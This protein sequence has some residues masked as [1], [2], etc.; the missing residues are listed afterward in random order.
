ML[1]IDTA[2]RYNTISVTV[3]NFLVISIAIGKKQPIW[4]LV[5]LKT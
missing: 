3:I 4:I 5:K 2:F 1:K